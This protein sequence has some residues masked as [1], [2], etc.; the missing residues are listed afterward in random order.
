ML[1][2][3]PASESV[4]PAACFSSIAW[5]LIWLLC[6]HGD[7]AH[8]LLVTACLNF[9]HLCLRWTWYLHA[10]PEKPEHPSAS[11]SKYTHTLATLSLP[12]NTTPGFY[13]RFYNN[14]RRWHRSAQISKQLKII[15]LIIPLRCL[16]LLQVIS[17]FSK[18]NLY[19]CFGSPPLLYTDYS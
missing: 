4:K 7:S 12:Q 8:F 14:R 10:G 13:G 19:H 9:Q 17:N 18:A 5:L 1:I 11:H 15:L 6:L 2:S 16:F 3:T